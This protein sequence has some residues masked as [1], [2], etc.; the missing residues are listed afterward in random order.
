LKGRLTGV[1]I[2]LIQGYNDF[3]VSNKDFKLL[4][5][6]MPENIEELHLEDYNHLD[7]VWGDDG[8]NVQ[9]AKIFSFLESL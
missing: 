6:I 4:H 1:K 8:N 9:N 7:Y 2:L 3:L 5:D